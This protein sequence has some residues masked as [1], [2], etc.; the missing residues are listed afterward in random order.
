MVSRVKLSPLNWVLI[1]AD[2]LVL[3]ALIVWTFMRP[4]SSGSHLAMNIFVGGNLLVALAR[5]YRRRE[6]AKRRTSPES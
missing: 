3:G 6:M 4:L 5:Q 2:C 1:T